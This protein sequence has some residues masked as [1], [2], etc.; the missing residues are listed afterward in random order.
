MTDTTVEERV[1]AGT[2]PF[3]G[4]KVLAEILQANIE[5]VGMPQWSQADLSKKSSTST[6]SGS[7]PKWHLSEGQRSAPAPRTRATS[8]GSCPMCGWPFR[9]RFPV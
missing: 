9:H 6:K 5:R 3:N 1:F 2:W 7:R 4:N 8:P